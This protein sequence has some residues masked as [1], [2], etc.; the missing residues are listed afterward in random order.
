VT[1]RLLTVIAICFNHERFVLECLESIRAQTFQDFELIVVDDGSSDRSQQ[2]IRAWIDEHGVR[3]RFIA[4]STNRGLL[5]TLNEVLALVSGKYFAKVST[6]DVWLPDKLARQVQIMESLPDSVAVL[7][8]EAEQITEDGTLMPVR[9]LDQHHAG[10]PRP[11]SR[12]YDRLLGGNFIPSLTTMVRTSSVRAVGGYDESLVY[13]DWD[14]WLRLSRVYEFEYVDA[15]LARYRVVADSLIRTLNQRRRPDR[16]WS[17]FRILKKCVVAGLSDAS[18]RH[19]V[20]WQMGRCAEELLRHRDP[21]GL[22]G[23]SIYLWF[24]L[25]RW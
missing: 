12:I 1:M 20:I 2:I 16:L 21:R 7:Y 19:N 14:M 6:D 5:P 10:M 4:H 3:C 18:T 8:G 25:R 15:V 9:F 13:E 17:D 22:L 23:Q 24:R 11:Q